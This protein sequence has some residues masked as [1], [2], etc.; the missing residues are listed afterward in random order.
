MIKE[1]IENSLKSRNPELT[2][3]EKLLFSGNSPEKLLEKA[4]KYCFFAEKTGRMFVDADLEKKEIYWAG[5]IKDVTGY[6]TEEF[7][8]IYRED[9]KELLHPADRKRISQIMDSSLETGEGIDEEYRLRRQDGS[10]VHLETNVIFQKDEG[11]RPYRALGVFKDITEKV[12]F[13]QKLKRIEEKFLYMAEQTGQLILDIDTKTNKV[14]W[15]GALEE[16]TGFFAPEELSEVYLPALKDLIYPGERERVWSALEHSLKT[17]DKYYQEFWARKKDAS[18]IYVEN[19]AIFLKDE[20]GKVYRVLGLMKDITEKKQSR[21]KLEKS[22]ERLRTYMQNFKGIGFQLDQ[23][24]TPVMIQGA[25]KEILGYSPE[26]ILCGKIHC[27]DLVHPE[28]QKELLENQ[29]KLIEDPEKVINHEYR[30]RHREGTIKWV[31]EVIQSICDSKGKNWLFQGSIHDITDRKRAE[32]GLKKAEET[33][34]K[35]I[36]HR[37]KNNLQVISSLLDL[38]A[39]KFTSREVVEAFRESQ[40][41]IIS[42][43]MIHE[44]LYRSGDMETLDFTGYIQKLATE[45][46]RSYKLESAEISLQM[47]LE[48]GVYLYMDTAIPLGIII[49]ELISNS[50]KHAFPDGI[51]GEIRIKL[52]KTENPEENPRSCKNSRLI[53]LIS[54]NGSGIP[55]NIDFENPETLGLQL[56]NTLVKQIEGEIEVEMNAGTEFRIGV[57]KNAK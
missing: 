18:Y 42:M 41:R 32:D 38:E 47:D 21:E 45:L 22:E 46:F 37:I 13:R 5:A 43:S 34:K 14:E 52:Y 48:E 36:H 40:N 8:K 6:N 16:L 7:K 50:L 31:H 1:E 39:E 23:N 35:E 11:G 51:K 27:F 9:F 56:V 29:R 53:L 15:T 44:G 10:Y 3:G 19:S 33:R 20:E 54:D 4:E 24:F 28:D 30:V 26:E 17:G 12:L 55:E 49:N 25:V 57:G 2:P